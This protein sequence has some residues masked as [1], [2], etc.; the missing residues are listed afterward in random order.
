[1]VDLQGDHEVLKVVF[2][3]RKD[4]CQ[5]RANGALLQLLDTNLNA[6]QTRTLSQ[7]LVQPFTFDAGSGDNK[8]TSAPAAN[9]TQAINQEP[10]M[11][12]PSHSPQELQTQHRCRKCGLHIYRLGANIGNP[13]YIGDRGSCDACNRDFNLHDLWSC[14]PCCSDFCGD[15]LRALPPIEREE[16]VA[17]RHGSDFKA[18]SSH[19]G[20]AA[21]VGKEKKSPPNADNQRRSNRPRVSDQEPVDRKERNNPPPERPPRSQVRQA[22]PRP[23]R[24]RGRGRGWDDRKAPGSPGQWQANLNDYEE[25]LK[26]EDVKVGVSR[27][28][29]AMLPTREVTHTDMQRFSSLPENDGAQRC[30]ICLGDYELGEILR[31]LP[32]LHVF[33]AECIDRWLDGAKTCPV[34]KHLVHNT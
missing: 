27:I 8:S 9:A 1:M 18:S 15:C 14:P 20:R 6:W 33:H 4:C 2:F 17:R 22:H 29:L 12:A 23:G 21:S 3:N 7:E 10:C 30:T 5:D 31:S 19:R 28:I 13:V 11:S 32:C 25:L 34:C 26:L 16:P 24:G